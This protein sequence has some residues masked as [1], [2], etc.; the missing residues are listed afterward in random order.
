MSQK[1]HITEPE[2]P[3][4]SG[5]ALGENEVTLWRVDLESVRAD[6]SRWNEFLS[7]EEKQRARRFHFPEDR[8]RYT[9]SRAFLRRILAAYLNTDPAG[10]TFSYSSKEKP[11][12]AGSQASSRLAFNVSHSGGIALYA[13]T[14]GR[15][16]GVDVEH[17]RRDFD[18]E[19][20]ARRFF[21]VIEQLQINALPQPERVEA[22]F[23]CWTRK[24]AYLKATGDGLSLPLSQFDVSIEENEAGQGKEASLLLA[25]RP[26]PAEAARWKLS[27][28][29][30]GP[31]YRAAVC[32]R[33]YDWTLTQW[34]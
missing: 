4:E 14:R 29:P 26:D 32:V 34:S 31:G 28:V 21:S 13:F 9:A 15:Q 7:S 19:P 22:F 16:L 33:G 11:S 12:L 27:D 6:E 24:E 17:I 5:L 2:C 25:T 10:L 8:Q 3:I 30:C 23:R 20:I 1:M 18:V